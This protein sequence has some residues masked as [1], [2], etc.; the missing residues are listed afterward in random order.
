MGLLQE[1]V[2]MGKVPRL[3]VPAELLGREALHLVVQWGRV[4]LQLVL[5]AGMVQED[6]EDMV[7]HQVVQQDKIQTCLVVGMVPPPTDCRVVVHN[8]AVVEVHSQTAGEES[9]LLGKVGAH[10]LAEVL[11]EGD[12]WLLAV[13]GQ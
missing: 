13:L 11:G 10:T 4:V 5:L 2:L 6:Q 12:L 8:L 3:Q 7:V 1:E 9:I